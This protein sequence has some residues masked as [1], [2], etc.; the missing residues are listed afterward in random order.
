MTCAA[1]VLG[2]SGCVDNSQGPRA[3][4]AAHTDAEGAALGVSSPGKSQPGSADPSIATSGAKGESRSDADNEGAI[5]ASAAPTQSDSPE[6]NVPADRN[7]GEWRIVWKAVTGGK[8]SV[9]AFCDRGEQAEK[10]VTIRDGAFSTSLRSSRG[11]YGS[12][13][14]S[15]TNT[16]RL[17]LA[18]RGNNWTVGARL[19]TVDLSGGST[20]LEHED[21]DCGRYLFTFTRVSG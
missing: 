13:K 12:L 11:N 20:Q 21:P 16:G 7:D 1:V 18:Y 17:K 2:L 3:D 9:D 19:V 8:F 4:D 6:A 14:G 5:L 10:V 15:H